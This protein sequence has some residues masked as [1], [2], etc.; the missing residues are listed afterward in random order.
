M[1]HR[2]NFRNEDIESELI[3]DTDSDDHVEDTE[4]DEDDYY[5]EEEQPSPTV[6]RKH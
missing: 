3:C 6:Q 2:R 5:D 4:S 1:A